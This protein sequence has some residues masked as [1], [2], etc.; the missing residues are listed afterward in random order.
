MK[1]KLL[2]MT[3][4]L[5][6]AMPLMMAPT[7]HANPDIPGD[8]NSDGDVNILDIAL[9]GGQYKLQPSDPKYNITIVGKA[10]LAPPFDG[11][12][13]IMDIVTMIYHWTG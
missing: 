6:V 13:N 1:A 5:T 8:I 7:I 2:L 10:D 9:A 3:L 11:V 12:L 4:A